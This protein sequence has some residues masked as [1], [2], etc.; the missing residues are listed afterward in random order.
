MP[1]KEIGIFKYLIISAFIISFSLKEKDVGA[2]Y[3]GNAKTEFSLKDDKN[4]DTA[5]LRQSGIFLGDSGKVGTVQQMDF[6]VE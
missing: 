6:A 1:L 4:Q 2:I 5:K 3:L